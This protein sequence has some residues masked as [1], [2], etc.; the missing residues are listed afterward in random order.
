M[1]Q[2]LTN[3]GT[4]QRWGNALLK[5][6]QWASAKGAGFY[7][8]LKLTEQIFGDPAMLVMSKTAAAAGGSTTTTGTQASLTGTTSSTTGPTGAKSGGSGSVPPTTPNSTVTPGQ[9]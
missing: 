7:T 5:T 6:Q 2:L 9:F 1:S 8:D 3:A 4:T